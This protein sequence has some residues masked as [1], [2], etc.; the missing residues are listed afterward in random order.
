MNRV[1]NQLPEYDVLNL[2]R[3][4]KFLKLFSVIGSLSY[5]TEFSRTPFQWRIKLY[6]SLVIF[7]ANTRH[8]CQEYFIFNLLPLYHAW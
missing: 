5:H 3:H 7:R 2:R 8:C 6:L 4:S 1:Q